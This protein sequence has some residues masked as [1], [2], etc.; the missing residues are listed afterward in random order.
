[1]STGENLDT[2]GHSAPD[3]ARVRVEI[4]A[5]P[6]APAIGSR[7]DVTDRDGASYRLTRVRVVTVEAASVCVE[8][9]WGGSTRWLP[10]A[11]WT[12]AGVSVRA[13]TEGRE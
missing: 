8:R 7:W 12:H 1:M 3:N 5:V 10:L 4:S 11:L 9:E 13:V 2:D 6:D